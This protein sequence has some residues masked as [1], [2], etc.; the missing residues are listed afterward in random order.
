MK[1]GSLILLCCFSTAALQA[2]SASR[3]GSSQSVFSVEPIPVRKIAL[4]MRLATSGIPQKDMRAVFTAESPLSAMYIKRWVI[5]ASPSL[6]DYPVSGDASPGPPCF[7]PVAIKAV[8]SVPE[9]NVEPL[10]RGEFDLTSSINHFSG[11][12]A[13]SAKKYLSVQGQLREHPEWTQQ[14]VARLLAS[15]GA[16]YGPDKKRHFTAALP[17][18]ALETVFGPMHVKAVTSV[19][20]GE[21]WGGYWR[22]R[23]AFVKNP[24]S[25]LIMYFEPFEGQLQVLYR[26]GPYR[27]WDPVDKK[28]KWEMPKEYKE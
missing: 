8:C 1:R 20:P 3:P 6:E 25:G 27:V 5:T 23:T 10:F 4:V 16:R 21:G 7:N 18:K 28:F 19:K 17:L 12:V 14:Q 11:S 13:A 26:T 2:Q 9:P 24:N 22:V 15:A